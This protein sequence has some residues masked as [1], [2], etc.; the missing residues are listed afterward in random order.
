MNGRMPATKTAPKAINVFNPLGWQMQPWRSIAPVL[1]L[2]GSAGGGKSRLAGEKLHGFCLKYPDATGLLLRKAREYAGKSIVPFL[3]HT[4]MGDDPHV[5][6][7]KGDNTFVYENGSRLYVGGMRDDSQ[8]EGVRSI[9][10]GG[11]LDIV[12]M[13]EASQFTETDYNE[14]TARM[15]GRAA[16]WT[17]IVLTTN[18]GYPSHWIKR[19]LIDGGEAE[20]YYSGA[21]DN[22]HNPAS[23]TATLDRLTGVLR[24]RL[25]DGR[26]VQAEG[27]VYPQY[28]SELHLLDPFSIPSH[29]R[30]FRA[31][32]FGYTN[33]FVC[34][35]WAEDDDGRLY[36][37]R[38][39][40]M[41]GRT[42]RAH[43]EQIK[44]LSAD[45]HIEFTVADHDAEDRATLVE[46]GIVTGAA[47]KAITVGIQRVTERLQV[48]GDGKPRL[49]FMRG[50]LVEL[51]STLEERKKPTCTA[52][53]IE[54]YAWQKAADGSPVKEFPTKENDHGV[55][56]M[57]YMVQAAWFGM[58][59]PP[60]GTGLVF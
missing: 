33:P 31:I 20:V 55:D 10:P 60:G 35:W 26:W 48:A 36:L 53:E 1:L 6:Y 24:Q 41:T 29:W 25:R 13:E 45:E 18:P 54:G 39:I 15:R 27:A 2:T 58:P 59:A 11:G 4:V 50:A 38:E 32:D 28:S 8:R 40:Y 49:F 22:P 21:R 34:Q 12:W 14:V 43:A 9:G 57:R 16:P 47:E 7:H 52:E 51:D 56:A 30:R 23:Y 5:E 3:L 19:R 37:Y 46:S 44:R 42:V 17:Q